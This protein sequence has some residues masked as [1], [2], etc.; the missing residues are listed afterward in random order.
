[1]CTCTCTYAMHL[2][3]HGMHACRTHVSLIHSRTISIHKSSCSI[4]L[5]H[6]ISPV[7]W[8]DSEICLYAVYWTD[9][10]PVTTL[11]IVKKFGPDPNC[12][13]PI[14]SPVYRYH[15]LH[16]QYISDL[17]QAW[18]WLGLDSVRI[19]NLLAGVI[20][21][22]ICTNWSCILM[23]Q[24]I[25]WISHQFDSWYNW[26]SNRETI[27]PVLRFRYTI[28]HIC[29]NYSR[30]QSRS[31]I[32]VSVNSFHGLCTMKTVQTEA[33]CL[34]ASIWTVFV[35][36]RTTEQ[37]M[38]WIHGRTDIWTGLKSTVLICFWTSTDLTSLA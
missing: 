9:V 19:I 3:M 8:P 28:S 38:E 36:Q 15:K 25:H 1:M 22:K 5:Y 4:S 13:E 14:Q 20:K 35:V 21:P 11:S 7:I 10:Y 18:W 12:T 24:A 2:C 32:C 6:L 30:F 23:K 31:N 33:N 37:A 34:L 29:S 16:G 26:G 17:Y 27:T